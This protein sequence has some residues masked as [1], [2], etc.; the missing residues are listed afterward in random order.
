MRR[1]T[2]APLTKHAYVWPMQRVVAMKTLIFVL[3]LC[4]AGCGGGGSGDSAPISSPPAQVKAI[5]NLTAF[6]GDS[7]TARWNLGAYDQ[8][9]TLNFGVAGDTTP[10]MLARFND[11]LA[12]QPGVVVILGGI[13]DFVEIGLD[14]T[15]IDSI[16][17]MAQQA[18]AAGVRVVICSVMPQDATFNPAT[19]AQIEAFNQQLITLAQANGYLY[20]DYYDAFLNPDGSLNTSL[21]NADELHPNDAGYAAMWKVLAPLLVEDIG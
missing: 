12:A 4:L 7:I 16:K 13:N 1:R 20:A 2:P 19:F 3:S 17:A 18:S 8:N 21:L 11:V 10:M 9:P 14:G 6:M 15:S 5:S